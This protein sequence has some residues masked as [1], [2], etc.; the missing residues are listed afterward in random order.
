MT[1]GVVASGCCARRGCGWRAVPAR[2][3]GSS[4]A[5][6]LQ[7]R[8]TPARRCHL[9]LFRPPAAST[10]LTSWPRSRIRGRSAV[11]GT[12]W[13]GYRRLALDAGHAVR[14]RLVIAIYGKTVR[15][16]KGK[17][18]KAPHLVAALAHGIGAV[19]GQV[20]VD[21]KSLVTTGSAT[22]LTRRTSPGQN[23]DPPR[24][25]ASLRSLAI[26]ILRLD[27]HTNIAAAD[28]HHARDPQRA[29]KLLQAE[30]D[31][32]GSLVIAHDQPDPSRS[33]SPGP[34]PGT[35]PTRGLRGLVRLFFMNCC[36]TMLACAR[37]CHFVRSPESEA[38][39]G[40][41]MLPARTRASEQ[42]WS[43]HRRA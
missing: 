26:S 23:G 21:E 14:V 38:R 3:D 13:P 39:C 40:Y 33:P 24:V 9:R 19:L 5:R 7:S 29:L 6:R 18:G 34:Q 10:C 1:C 28:R 17:K 4:H 41:R 22:L 27:G 11:A 36:Q 25:M 43:K 31:F 32:A 15:G 12:R 37:S 16:A 20:A 35:G 42:T 30:Y 2:N 8:G